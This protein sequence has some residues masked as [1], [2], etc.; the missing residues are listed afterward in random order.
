MERLF[1]SSF[2]EKNMND[3]PGGVFIKRFTAWAPGFTGGEDWKAWACG[4][5]EIPETT[6][7]PGLEFT[8]PGFRRRLSQISRMTIQVI[9]DILPLEDGA[10]IVLVSFH[11]EITQ[12]MKLNKTLTTENIMMPAL[13]SLSIFNTPAALATIALK[14]TNVSYTVV[15]PVEYDF[16]AGFT[17]AVAALLSGGKEVLLVYADE[18]VPSEYKVFNFKCALP[19]AF[20]ALLSNRE[21]QGAVPALTV[22][23]ESPEAFLKYLLLK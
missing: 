21:T 15:F 12:Q 18:L 7:G 22:P 23:P 19:L 10:K 5:R 6:E 2:P 9:H 13:F 20:A 4:T 3:S 11:G 16:S 1:A 8:A 14:L 17:A